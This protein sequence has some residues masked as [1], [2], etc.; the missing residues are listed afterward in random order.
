MY[1]TS[2][3]DLFVASHVVDIC[4]PVSGLIHCFR[5]SVRYRNYF[6]VLFWVLKKKLVGKNA[7][8]RFAA[9][10]TSHASCNA[11]AILV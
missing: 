3:I 2:Q 5:M 4:V 7:H 8:T 11:F 6:S 10:V 9:L 1:E